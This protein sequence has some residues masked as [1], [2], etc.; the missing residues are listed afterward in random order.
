[1]ARRHSDTGSRAVSDQIKVTYTD[2]EGFKTQAYIDEETGHGTNKH[3]DVPVIIKS[4]YY[5]WVQVD[6]WKWSW[7][8]ATDTYERTN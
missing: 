7:D 5:G 6:D 3:S 1:M 8:A 2:R 4:S